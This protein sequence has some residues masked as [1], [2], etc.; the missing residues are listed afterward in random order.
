MEFIKAHWQLALYAIASLIGCVVLW[1]GMHQA[2]TPVSMAVLA[3][4]A[5][6]VANEV[7]TDTQI[8]SG[9]VKTLPKA[10]K[11]KLNLPA[12]VQADDTRQVLDAVTLPA[13]DHSR[14]V[15]PVVDTKTGNT[16]TYVQRNPLPLFA[17]DTT[18]EA[19]LF[20]GF[21]NGAAAL[22]GEARQSL[23]KIR[24]VNLGGMASFDQPLGGSQLPPSSFIGGGAWGHW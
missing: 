15:T 6:E 4:P 21:R 9:T 24:A 20:I 5:A 12:Q 14:T 10:V 18:G 8:Q 1:A 3:T 2:R 17:I 22:R 23:F 7:K 11:R 16:E 19:G 13:D